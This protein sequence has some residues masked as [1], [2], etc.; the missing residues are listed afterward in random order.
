MGQLIK[1]ARVAVL[2]N[3]RWHEKRVAES[4]QAAGLC[5]DSVPNALGLMS[6]LERQRADLVVVEDSND[7]LDACLA[8][9]RFRG[10]AGVPVIALGQGSMQQIIHALSNGASDYLCLADTGEILANRVLA[11]IALSRRPAQRTNVQVGELSLDA[12]SRTL[13]GP[14]SDEALTSR[15][16]ELAWVLFEHAGEVVNL[17]LLSQRVWGRDASLAKRTIE[18]HISRVRQKLSRE[19]DGDGGLVQLQAIHNIG[20]RLT[21]SA[22]LRAHAAA[23]SIPLSSAA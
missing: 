7:E 12:S 19:G 8:S 11:R 5:V 22:A 15:E 1:A 9:L 14:S 6:L 20:Y 16:F 10:L 4:M 13:H 3:D 17:H 18:Q 2:M 23:E 21:H